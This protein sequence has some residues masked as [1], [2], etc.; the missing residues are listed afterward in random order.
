MRMYETDYI[1][2]EAKLNFVNTLNFNILKFCHEK[3][4][5]YVDNHINEIKVFIRLIDFLLNS[6]LS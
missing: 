4:E 5:L 1:N 3:T 2:L 6:F